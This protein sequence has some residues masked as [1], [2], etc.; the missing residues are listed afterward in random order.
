M[1]GLINGKDAE[2]I[3]AYTQHRLD[4]LS[5]PEVWDRYTRS[6]E[7]AELKEFKQGCVDDEIIIEA[8]KKQIPM[9]P[10]TRQHGWKMD[11]YCPVCGVQQKSPGTRQ[12]ENGSYCGRCGQ[13]IQWR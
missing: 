6:M 2:R 8:L 7:C 13:K 12:I 11:H 9:K 1:M 3:A 4:E 5:K 10:T